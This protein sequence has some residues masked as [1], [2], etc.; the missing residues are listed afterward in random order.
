MKSLTLIFMLIIFP[1]IFL[2]EISCIIFVFFPLFGQITQRP[3]SIV[4]VNLLRDKTNQD[5]RE[6]SM[7]LVNL[8]QGGQMTNWTANTRG[9]GGRGNL[10]TPRRR[11]VLLWSQGY[12]TAK[13]NITMNKNN[14]KT[15]WMNKIER[16]SFQ[17]QRLWFCVTRNIVWGRGLRVLPNYIPMEMFCWTGSRFDN[18]GFVCNRVI[19][20]F[21]ILEV[22]KFW[23][24]SIWK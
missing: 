3:I 5:C 4:G 7:S 12:C 17:V 8:S 19:G 6:D 23:W 24:V 15:A 2:S 11:V 20:I 21:G 9:G 14:P 18:L 13:K 22:R 16:K 10:S 1:F